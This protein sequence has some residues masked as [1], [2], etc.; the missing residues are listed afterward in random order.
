[1]NKI[2]VINNKVKLFLEDNTLEVEVIDR[3][4]IFDVKK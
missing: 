3:F 1:M 4:E 2:K